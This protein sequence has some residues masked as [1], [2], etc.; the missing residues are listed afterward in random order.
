MQPV[1][2]IGE[3]S[4]IKLVD[5][6]SGCNRPTIVKRVGETGHIHDAPKILFMR[7]RVQV[8]VC[9]IRRDESGKL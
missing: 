1:Q 5:Y 9:A 4:L 3:R 7:I 8:K 6:D 2:S